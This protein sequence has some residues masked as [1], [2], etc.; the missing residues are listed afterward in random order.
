MFLHDGFNTMKI[1]SKHFF[2]YHLQ[3][4]R[5][6]RVTV[7]GTSGLVKAITNIIIIIRPF[8]LIRSTINYTLNI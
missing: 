6:P 1:I 5:V 3:A 4:F 7:L 8:V 2:V